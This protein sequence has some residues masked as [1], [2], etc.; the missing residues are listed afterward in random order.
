MF[1]RRWVYVCT[2]AV[3]GFRGWPPAKRAA[4]AIQPVRLPSGGP[5]LAVGGHMKPP[6]PAPAPSRQVI[7]EAVIVAKS[8]PIM[9]ATRHA[10]RQ[11]ATR[12]LHA[13]ADPVAVSGRLDASVF[14]SL[15]ADLSPS[16][17]SGS[18]ISLTNAQASSGVFRRASGRPWAAQRCGRR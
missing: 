4:V 5:P 15:P 12:E 13:Y 2:V 14:R 1:V 11:R 10:R 3:Y 8:A 9:S 6:H 17:R 7:S 16:E 18:K